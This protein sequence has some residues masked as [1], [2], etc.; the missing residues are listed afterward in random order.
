[1]RLVKSSGDFLVPV[2]SSGHEAHA[3]VSDFA[4]AANI[5]HTP[6]RRGFVF[7]KNTIRQC[8]Y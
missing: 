5:A 8:Y 1:M 2:V 6:L 4:K 7:L 3:K